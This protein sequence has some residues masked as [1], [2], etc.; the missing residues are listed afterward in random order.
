MENSCHSSDRLPALAFPARILCLESP[1]WSVRN[2]RTSEARGII[3]ESHAG[4][5]AQ[6]P[7]VTLQIDEIVHTI[8]SWVSGLE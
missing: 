5:N 7:V 1:R 8:R 3:A 4:G 2:K 6:S